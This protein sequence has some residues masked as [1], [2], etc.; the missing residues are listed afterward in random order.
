LATGINSAIL[1]F[2]FS[3][4]PLLSM[5]SG[6][7]FFSFPPDDARAAL[8]KRILRRSK[9]LYLPLVVWNAAYLAALYAVFWVNPHASVFTHLNRLN[10]DFSTA[11]WREYGNALF[12]VTSEPLAFQFWFVRDLFVT[13]LI[14]PILWLAIRHTPWTGAVAL[15][16]IWL[17]GWSMGIF[18][19]SDV[20][21]FFYMGALIRRKHMPTTIPLRATLGLIMLYV[22][23]ACLRALA[24]YAVPTAAD[25]VNP[26]W[27]DVATRAMRIIGVLACWGTL[28]R[29]AQTRWGE[30]IAEFGGLAFFLHSAHWPLLAIVKAMLW[31]LMP[32]DTDAWM[33]VHYAASVSLT[34]MIGLGLGI[35]LASKAPKVF[36]LM[37]GGRLLGQ[38]IITRRP[39]EAPVKI[40]ETIAQ[41]A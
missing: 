32:Q 11:G 9:S 15:C 40:T 13:V 25:L 29:L 14:S 41:A 28:Y 22:T 6:W 34:V 33:L 8:K 16:V 27:L 21:F 2:F 5:I 36:A 4:V 3:V 39:A 35:A 26:L 10:M 24:P 18:I 1:F 12:A 37:N 38:S 7:L 17:G 30:R 19:R 31:R 23:L 20:P